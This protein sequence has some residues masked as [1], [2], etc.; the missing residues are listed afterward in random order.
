VYVYIILGI[1]NAMGVGYI[2]WIP[3]QY[4]ATVVFNNKVVLSGGYVG[5][6][7]SSGYGNDV[8]VLDPNSLEWTCSV[9][10]APWYPRLKHVM[11][12]HR[13]SIYLLGG[14]NQNDVWHSLD[15][16]SWI[17]QT[18]QAPWSIRDG[19]NAASLGGKM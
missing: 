7:S 6:G 11:I 10:N 12:V 14:N 5:G 8:W 19:H 9:Y 2:P 13:G 18:A 17:Q 1:S 16:R 4:H 15:T 3:R